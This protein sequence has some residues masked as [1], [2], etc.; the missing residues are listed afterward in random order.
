[1]YGLD[2][3]IYPMYTLIY[4][5]ILLHFCGYVLKLLKFGIVATW[6]YYGAVKMDELCIAGE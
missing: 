6:G 4:W 5:C 2:Y 3:V 1:M